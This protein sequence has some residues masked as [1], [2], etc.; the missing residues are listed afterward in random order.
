MKRALSVACLLLATG[1]VVAR[2]QGYS[3]TGVTLVQATNVTTAS[4]GTWA[5][6]WKTPFNTSQPFV[7][8]HYIGVATAQPVQC[9]LTSSTSTSASGKCYAGQSTLL[10]LSIV[11]TGITVLPFAVSSGG[12]AVQ[13]LGRDTTQ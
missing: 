1:L 8:A 5:V 2:G 4:D 12:I 10:S 3:S 7:A 13:V 6:T 11:T 9:M